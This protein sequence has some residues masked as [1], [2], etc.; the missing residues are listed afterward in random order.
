MQINLNRNAR[1]WAMWCHLAALLQFAT[2]IPIPFVGFVGPLIIWLIKKGDSPFIDENGK[3][4]LNFQIS[5]IVYI[6]VIIPVALVLLF[7]LAVISI[8]IFGLLVSIVF[9]SNALAE[10]TGTFTGFAIIGLP[11]LL[12]PFIWACLGVFQ[13]IVIINAAFRASKGEMYRYPLTW[14]FLK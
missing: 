5:V 2:L 4:S 3:E 10:L 14:R 8:F 11:L 13:F 12:A 1:N 7:L 6:F 9:Q